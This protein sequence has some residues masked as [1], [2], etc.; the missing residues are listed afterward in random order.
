MNILNYKHNANLNVIEK[1]DENEVIDIKKLVKMA[2]NGKKNQ[3]KKNK[4]K[5]KDEELTEL[6]NLKDHHEEGNPLEVVRN[7]IINSYNIENI[8][9]N[10]KDI[11]RH[12]LK[13]EEMPKIEDYES[14]QTFFLFY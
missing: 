14:K 13:D 11:L 5:L 9:S 7:E 4:N 6:K 10:K 12:I 1:K 2:K 3:E 8:F